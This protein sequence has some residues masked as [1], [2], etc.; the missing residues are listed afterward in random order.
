MPFRSMI[1][2]MITATAVISG[3]AAAQQVFDERKYPAFE[4]QWIRIGA[5]ERYD[6]TKPPA[7]GQEAPLTPEYQAI[8]EANLAEVAKGGFGDDPVYT[9]IPEGMPRAM[10]LILPMEFVIKRDVSYIHMEYLS[11]LRRI[12]TDGRGFPNDEAPSWMGYSI[13]RWIDEDGKGRYD[14][15]EVETRN[16]KNPRTFDASGMPLHKD[17][18]TV[19]K[20]RF[21]LDK[22][23]PD[24]LHDQ[25]TTYDHAL[26]RPWTVTKTMRR[27]RKPIW[28]ESVCNENNLQVNIGNEHYMLNEAGELMPAKKDQPPPDLKHFSQSKK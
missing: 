25:I 15:L 4:G 22:A 16:L 8:F 3:P 2:L 19:V 20:E 18:Q 23:D 9:C 14:V 28:V 11:M 10:N 1:G 17:A 26:T 13:G 24:I 7:R 27:E 21:Y 5:I 6:Q 12:Y